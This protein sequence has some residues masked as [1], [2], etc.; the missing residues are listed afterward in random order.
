MG[1]A[2]PSVDATAVSHLVS[3]RQSTSGSAAAMNSPR[4]LPSAERTPLTFQE[5]IFA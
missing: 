1:K 3:C 4:P 2:R 5:K